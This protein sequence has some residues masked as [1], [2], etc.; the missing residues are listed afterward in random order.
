MTSGIAHDPVLIVMLKA[1]RPGLVKTRLAA[2]VGSEGAAAIYRRLVAHQLSQVPPDWPV[3]VHFAPSDAAAEMQ[4]WL[5]PK[6]RYVPQGAGDLGARLVEAVRHSINRGAP[7]VIVVGGDCPGLDEETLLEAWRYLRTHE[8]VIGPACDGGYYLIGLRQTWAD[9]FR[10]IPWSTATVL[11][12]TLDR[13]QSIGISPRLLEPKEDVDDVESWFRAKE[14]WPRLSRPPGAI[15]VV[16]PALNEEAR[17]G[18][19][20]D[21]VQAALPG[22]EVILVDGGSSDATVAI[23]AARGAVVVPSAPGRGGQCRAG[24]ERVSSPWI[25]FLHADTL[26]PLNAGSL[27]DRFIRREHAHIATFRVQFPDGGR[28]MNL[29]SRLAQCGDCVL[30]RFGDQGILVRRRF[31]EAMGGFPAWPLFE[32]VRL[33]QEARKRTRVHWLE[34]Y[35]QTSARRFKRRG[36][37]RQRWLNVQ[38]MLRYLAG[39]S[40]FELAKRYR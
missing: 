40:P 10:D 31:Y 1:P 2:A 16:I 23:A 38:L 36:Y 39:A 27:C 4:A 5:G 30:T 17:I 20:L 35:V 18:A 24:A 6:Y 33:L 7:A 25:L 12:A 11:A 37:L 8:A 21:R 3:E 34:G 14:R 32:D 22:A 29:L 26:L 28:W 15:S 13:F 9:V 19:T